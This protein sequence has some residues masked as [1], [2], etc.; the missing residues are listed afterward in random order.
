MPVH[1]AQIAATF[2]TLA[3]LLEIEEANPFRVRAYRNAARIIE[4]MPQELA[5]L[6][7]SGKDLSEFPGI[8]KDLAGK[9]ATIVETGTLPLLDEVERRTPEALSQLTHI[10]GL[11]PKR[12]RSLY[13]RLHVQSVDDL[14]RAVEKQQV[15]ELPGF[16]AKTEESIRLGLQRMRGQQQR[17]K[18]IDAEQ[19]AEPLQAWLKSVPGVAAVQVAG[20][21]RR[22]RET[23]GDLDVLVTCDRQGDVM[24]RFIHHSEVIQVVARGETRSTVRFGSGLQVDLRVVPQSSF[25]AALHYFTGSKAHN[26]A[27]RKLAVKRQLKINEYGVFSGEKRI[28]G[29]TEEEV[30]AQVGLPFIE[31]ELREDRGEVEAAAQGRLPQLVSLEQIRGDLHLHTKATD[32]RY[33]LEEMV[34]AAAELGYAYVAV[35]DHSRRVTMAKG[36]DESRLAEQ[37]TQIDALQEKFP[38]IRILKGIELDILEDGTLDLPDRILKRLDLRVCSVHYQHALPRERQTERIIRAMDNPYFNILAHPSGRLINERE[39]Y[40]VEME[41]VVEA[42]AERGCFIEL[43]A[44]PSRLDATDSTCMLAKEHGVKVAIS[45]DAH[46]IGDLRFMRFGI[47]QA[48]RGWLEAADVLNTR[49]LEQLLK[50]FKR[51]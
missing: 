5:D 46:S 49:P 20:S 48:R 27:I 9:I 31:P 32:G 36:L 37:L 35:T 26:I 51:T 19:I 40:E 43:N 15:R 50:L 34:R 25:G 23:V 11:G 3:D 42:A 39:P 29:R 30:F 24:D 38:T 47:G 1:N 4:N 6:L 8:G 17:M 13:E 10:A 28:A 14:A 22:R 7:A 45:T 18:L 41:R 33:S 21:Y 2:D 44:Q 16:G 12:V